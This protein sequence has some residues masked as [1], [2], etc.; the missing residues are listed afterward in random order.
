M[1]DKSVRKWRG[2]EPAEL[3]KSAGQWQSLEQ[4][5]SFEALGH[6]QPLDLVIGPMQHHWHTPRMLLPQSR[7]IHGSF[8]MYK[9]LAWGGKCWKGS[10]F[11]PR[12]CHGVR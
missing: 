3:A 7:A 4:L 8:D 6:E 5:L 11:R 2:N 9:A 12:A 1:P 10:G